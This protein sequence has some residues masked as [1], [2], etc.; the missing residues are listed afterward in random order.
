MKPTDV[1]KSNE[2]EVWN[3]SFCHNFSEYQLP[4]F[5]IGDT[6]RISKYESTL[7]KGYEPNFTEEFFKVA[8]VIGGD[9]NV[10]ELEDLEDEPIIGKFYEEEL[11]R[12]DKKDDVY[13]VK[14]VRLKKVREKKMVLVI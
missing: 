4:K 13:K 6:V 1:N 5:K 11:S 3:T 10:Y 7:T 8:K 9:P 2:N 12:V 14:I